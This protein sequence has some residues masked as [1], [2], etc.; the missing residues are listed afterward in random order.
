[1]VTSYTT[2]EGD[3][4]D[5]IARKT[6]GLPSEAS[7]IKGSNPGVVEPLT[8]GIT[9][10]IPDVIGLPEPIPPLV[11]IGENDVAILINGYQFGDWIK[12]EILES[13][14][15]V[16][17]ISLTTPFDFSDRRVRETFRPFTFQLIECYIGSER[18][19]KGTIIDIVPEVTPDS[20]ILNINAYSVAGVLQDCP[21]P[22]SRFPIEY[23]FFNIRQWAQDLADPFGIEV[24]F[25]DDNGEKL[26]DVGSSMG[27]TSLGAEQKILPFLAGLASQRNF[28]ISSNKKGSLVF[29]RGVEP[30]NAVAYLVETDTLLTTVRPN[31]NANSY[32]SHLTGI[33]QSRV[34]T[35]GD[36]YTV[37]NKRLPGVVRP[38]T[39]KVSDTE[40]ASLEEVV[41]TRAGRM[42]ANMV[43][44]DITVSSWRDQRG[45]LW[46]PNTTVT[47]QYPSAMIYNDYEFVVRSVK[48]NK[49]AENESAV[50]NLVLPGVFNAQIP[51]VL[52]WDL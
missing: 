34:G 13:I 21:M 11:G 33:A 41:N 14:T 7:R 37:V 4:F 39:F 32:Y 15:S 9:L 2:I 31:F 45:D 49:D 8:S 19:F 12:L 22:A 43:S 30:G 27:L 38:Y 51:E 6:S 35:I 42:F 26:L 5:T 17:A 52:P 28:I 20:S 18:I 50:L 3:N 16:T 1:M 40:N 25:L 46:R 44:Y 29:Q 47:L 23:T 36:Q 48:F 24:E 10:V